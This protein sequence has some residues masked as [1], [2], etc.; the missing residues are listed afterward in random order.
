MT[1]PNRLNLTPN[2]QARPLLERVQ[3]LSRET[4]IPVATI[5]WASVG[6]CLPGIEKSKSLSGIIKASEAQKES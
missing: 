5:I 1:H 6:H 4:G 3:A 2:A